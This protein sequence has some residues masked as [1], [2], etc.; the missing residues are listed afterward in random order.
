MKHLVSD[1][2]K[3]GWQ[4]LGASPDEGKTWE[5]WQFLIREPLASHR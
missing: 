4:V 3:V 5:S 1:L 2:P